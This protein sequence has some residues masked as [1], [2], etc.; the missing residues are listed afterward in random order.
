MYILPNLT[1]E[2][3]ILK[4]FV[5]ELLK[6]WIPQKAISS[7]PGKFGVFF[8][9]QMITIVFISF[10]FF[11]TFIAW[12]IGAFASKFVTNDKLILYL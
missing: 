6:C 9:P 7:P 4:L 2:K 3:S 8:R 5:T 1:K 12:F 10:H 11:V